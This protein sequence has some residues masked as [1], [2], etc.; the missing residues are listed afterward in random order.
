[1]SNQITCPH[2]NKAFTVDEAGY[3][4]ILK[5]VHDAEFEKELAT[6]LKLAEDAKKNEIELAE[7]KV[8]QAQTQQIQSKE[9]EI[10]NLKSEIKALEASKDAAIAN[11]IS[12]TKMKNVELEAK[13]ENAKLEKENVEQT[14]NSKFKE[15]LDY[16]DQEIERY[17]NM[18]LQ[19]ST[20]GI[21]ESLEQFCLTE[22]NKI[23]SAAFPKAAFGKDT[24]KTTGS[25][26]DFIFRDKTDMDVEYLSIMFEMKN[27]GDET[28]TKKKNEDF[29]AELD[30]DR[31]EKGCEYAVLVSMLEADSELYNVGIVDVSHIYPKMYVVR[32]QFFIP[33]ITLLRNA[34]LKTVD[35]RNE[36]AI[37][38]AQNVDITNFESDVAAWKKGFT[39][40]Y[41]LAADKYGD[42]IAEIDAA[43][44]K[45]QAAKES[46][47]GSERN[48]RLANDKLD[49]LT[50]KKLTRNNPTMK[51][52]FEALGTNE[53]EA[54]EAED[55]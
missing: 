43:I 44:K 52:R 42:A 4:A 53:S 1:M 47:T 10:N 9:I 35:A 29:L 25:Q 3:S 20:K 50:V 33:M 54:E 34:A 5:Q 7:A 49:D 26:G 41:K 19:L 45:L 13:I 28:K 12:E 8:L 24:D 30:K 2:C 14:L 22:F 36:L 51:A 32:P 46:L 17:K 18:K 27:E 21:G 23:R 38:Q 6:R 11:A 39:R 48:L 15:L 31:N 40:N 37:I 16:K 55:N